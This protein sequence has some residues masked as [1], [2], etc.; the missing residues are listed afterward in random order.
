[1]LAF[2][3]APEIYYFD[4]FKDFVQEFRT[5][6]T[7][8]ILTNQWIYEPYLKPLKVR[9][10]VIYQERYG[11]GE[12]TDLMMDAILHDVGRMEYK[13]IIAV[14]GGSIIDI[15][16][17]L[18]LKKPEKT[19]DLFTGKASVV[20]DKKLVIVPTTCGTGSEV[21]NVAVAALTGLNTKKGL[22]SD[23]L[24]ADAAVLIPESLHG[25][26]DSV[27][28]TSSIDALIH[29]VESY[30][31]PKSS[32]FTEMFSVQAIVW[33]LSAYRKIIQKGNSKEVRLDYLKDFCLAANYAGIAFGNAGCGA[34]HAMS[35]APGGAF[36]IPHGEANYLL[37]TPVLKKYREKCPQGI[38]LGKMEK[39]LAGQLK[40]STQEVYG[41]LDDLLN[42]FITKKALREYGMTQAQV[43]EF[44]GLTLKNQQRLLTNAY[45]ALSEDDIRSVYKNIF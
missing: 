31:S 40:C 18:S 34:V 11:N 14:G 1:M 4:T 20:R 24:Y 25:L 17:I 26:P 7:D 45:I 9:G 33:I 6:E 10:T 36:H 13:R 27:F 38:K 37:F 30:L 28:A 16:K 29:A 43:Q 41:N 2:Q 3:V 42:Q 32:P 15:A 21:T 12:P 23:E 8:L 19:E 5:E 39:L 44:T 22:A 35:Y